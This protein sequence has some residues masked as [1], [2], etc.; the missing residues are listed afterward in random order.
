MQLFIVSP[1]PYD[2]AEY[3]DDKRVIKIILESAQMISTAIG[4]GYKACFLNHPCNVWIREDPVH[5]SWVCKY[6]LALVFVY[7]ERYGKWH[8][9]FLELG[10]VFRKNVKIYDETPKYFA[11]VTQHK[12]VKDVFLA[13]RM[14]L[15]DKWTKDKRPPMRD[16][17]PFVF[18]DEDNKYL[19]I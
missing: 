6:F 3:L 4:K 15:R 13:Y 19:V 7:K 17:Q 1:D 9:S 2:C 12:D 14:E 16:K 10:D 5:L 11:N 18:E 8:K